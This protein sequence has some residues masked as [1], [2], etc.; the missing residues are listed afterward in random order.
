MKEKISHQILIC[1]KIIQHKQETLVV[2]YILPSKTSCISWVVGILLTYIGF[3]TINKEFVYT[4]LSV[5][6]WS[7]TWTFLTFTHIICCISVCPTSHGHYCLIESLQYATVLVIRVIFKVELPIMQWYS[8]ISQRTQPHVFGSFHTALFLILFNEVYSL[9]TNKNLINI[10]FI[11]STH[12]STS[13][14]K[15]WHLPSL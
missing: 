5:L 15:A 4:V 12:G 10:A 13:I 2:I 6:S 7:F 8:F 14:T 3:V 9:T 1:L 11:F